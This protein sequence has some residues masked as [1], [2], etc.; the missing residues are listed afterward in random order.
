MAL[1]L[2]KQALE[3][4]NMINGLIDH[5][6]L[7]RMIP[8]WGPTYYLATFYLLVSTYDYVRDYLWCT[9]TFQLP[10]F[11]WQI[12][13]QNSLSAPTQVFQ[14]CW[15]WSEHPPPK[16]RFGQILALWAELIWNNPPPPEDLDR[17]WHFGLSWSE[18]PPPPPKCRFGQILA[19]W[20]QLV[21]T[22]PPPPE[23]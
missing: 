20:V 7:R 4:Y 11:G 16:F 13:V 23:F 1:T 6:F 2:I 18:L 22:T 5:G 3:T 21:W 15:S 19:L 8:L 10:E 9:T 12:C 17:S 14:E